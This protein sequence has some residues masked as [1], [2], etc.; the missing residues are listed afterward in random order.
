[1]V[2]NDEPSL[3]VSVPASI[4]NHRTDGHGNQKAQERGTERRI[5]KMKR[6]L[7]K[8]KKKVESKGRK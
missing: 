8:E 3:K 1:M 2:Q 5:E 4:L 6:V 7:K